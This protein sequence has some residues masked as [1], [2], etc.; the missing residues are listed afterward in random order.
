MIY[1]REKFSDDDQKFERI[2]NNKNENSIMEVP[3]EFDEIS[4]SFIKFTFNFNLMRISQIRAFKT[5]MKYEF[6]EHYPEIFYSFGNLLEYFYK[7]VDENGKEEKVISKDDLL[8]EFFKKETKDEKGN[9]NNNILLKFMIL[10]YD[11]YGEIKKFFSS[12]EQSA[13]EW[14]IY[15]DSKDKLKDF[16]GNLK[17]RISKDLED[18]L[19]ENVSGSMME[20]FIDTGKIFKINSSHDLVKWLKAW[21]HAKPQI[22]KSL[23]RIVRFPFIYKGNKAVAIYRWSNVKFEKYLNEQLKAENISNED[24]ERYLEMI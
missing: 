7:N 23:N 22:K 8:K 20:F 12:A 3:I 4:V 18:I 17:I 16:I 24:Y 2:L 9:F 1:A 19:L 14:G 13:F 10:M 15:L 21:D 5:F 6:I 11:P